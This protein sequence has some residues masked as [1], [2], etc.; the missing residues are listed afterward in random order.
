MRALAR[1]VGLGRVL[2]GLTILWSP[3]FAARLA[4]LPKDEANPSF[5]LVSRLTGNRELVLGT[6]LLCAPQPMM[7]TWLRVSAAID[8]ADVAVSLWS[9]RD[10]VSQRAAFASAGAAAGYAAL[11]L[12]AL[13]G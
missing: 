5:G 9:M 12:L 3:R 1:T 13:R 11:E 7:P 2:L 6:V 4:Q 10:G 8:A